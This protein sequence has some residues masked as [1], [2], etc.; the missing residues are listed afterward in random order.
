MHKN[1]SNESSTT[2]KKVHPPNH[3]KSI[4]D[5]ELLEM[6]RRSETGHTMPCVGHV[7]SKDDF[8]FEFKMKRVSET[9]HTMLCV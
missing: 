5:L 1:G 6:K 4:S 2:P 3:K 7:D 9:G 8:D